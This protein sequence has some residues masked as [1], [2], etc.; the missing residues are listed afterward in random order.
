MW[1]R[2]PGNRD[3]LLYRLFY[4]NLWKKILSRMCQL[5]EM[6]FLF[7]NLRG[8]R[9]LKWRRST[10]KR[11][12]ELINSISSRFQRWLLIFKNRRSNWFKNIKIKWNN[13]L[14]ISLFW[15]RKEPVVRSRLKDNSY[16]RISMILLSINFFR[17]I[18]DCINKWNW[19][20]MRVKSGGNKLGIYGHSCSQEK[21]D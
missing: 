6:I 9:W 4:S 19:Q 13:R 14:S 16:P 1:V 7:L 21:A 17:T 10:R 18:T 3:L 12:T 8:W 11:S 2:W 15:R 20:E 5:I